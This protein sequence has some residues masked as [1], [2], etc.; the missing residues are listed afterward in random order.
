MEAEGPASLIFDILCREA[1][2]HLNV[3]ISTKEL[4]ETIYEK[5]SGK[6]SEAA[7]CSLQIPVPKSLKCKE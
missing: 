4:E 7:T 6:F 2:I 3:K 5:F 1:E